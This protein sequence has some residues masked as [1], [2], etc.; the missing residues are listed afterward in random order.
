[1]ARISLGI[2]LR[3]GHTTT[4]AAARNRHANIPTCN[5]RRDL[6]FPAT[7]LCLPDSSSGLAR[8]LAEAV[9]NNTASLRSVSRNSTQFWNRWFG[10]FSSA[11]RIAASNPGGIVG[12]IADGRSGASCTTLYRTAVT[13]SA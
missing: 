2:L 6:L 12:S 10:S 11:L 1:M 5:A 9:R 7:F 4:A 13:L 8:I 3:C